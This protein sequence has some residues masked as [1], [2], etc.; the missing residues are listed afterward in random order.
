MQLKLLLK[1]IK[2]GKRLFLGLSLISVSFILFVGFVFLR[3]RQLC[4]YQQAVTSGLLVNK[5]DQSFCPSILS[6]SNW[7]QIISNAFKFNL[8]NSLSEGTLSLFQIKASAAENC[9]D[10]LN[11]LCWFGDSKP[12]LRQSDGFT[13]VVLI[14]L[15]TRGGKGLKNTDTI[16]LA[17]LDHAS[18]KVLLLSFP[19]D[20]YV[21]YRNPKGANVSYKINGIYALS[22]IEGLNGAI[23]QITGKPIHYYAYIN[24]TVFSES[25]TALGGVSINLEKPFSDLFPC[26]ELKEKRQ[27]CATRKGGFGRFQFPAGLNNFDAIDANIYARSR[28]ASSDFDRARRQQNVISAILKQALSQSKPLN[29]RLATYINLYNIFRAQVLTDVQLQD[30]A[31][32]FAIA[33]QLNDN[34][35]KVTL[36]PA[37]DGGRIVKNSGIIAGVGYS[38][39][40][41]DGSYRQFQNYISSIWNNL[42]FYSERPKILVVNASGESLSPDSVVGK[43]VNNVPAYSEI[44][45]IDNSN[46]DFERMRIYS[47]TDKA[48]SLNEL[49]SL[50]PGSLVFSSELDKVTRSDYQEDLLLIVGKQPL[51]N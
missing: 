4:G 31:G 2:P 28:Y 27:G 18:G 50:V 42:A 25:I 44:K 11:P 29:E 15:D 24:L 13:N 3:H 36:D 32:L 20:L 22:G 8:I 47:F 51:V 37:L 34:P 9:S 17:S 6:H 43:L 39:E 40:F 14:G 19:R 46:L 7:G 26:V 33:D 49:T 35:I 41:K 23:S 30:L 21:K 45:Y 38:I 5:S 48:S 12:S 10:Q 1:R 16:V